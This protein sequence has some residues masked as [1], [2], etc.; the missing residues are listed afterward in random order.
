[1]AAPNAGAPRIDATQ[2]ETTPKEA[3]LDGIPGTG[4]LQVMRGQNGSPMSVSG[5]WR[6]SWKD[7]DHDLATLLEAFEADRPVRYH[8]V[9]QD[10]SGEHRTVTTQVRLSSVGR[11]QYDS[12]A[13]GREQPTERHLF[14]FKPVNDLDELA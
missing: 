10:A 14:N 7:G 1:M 6:L 3:E 2:N 4:T 8:G 9:V 11:Y 13:S 12:A 5:T